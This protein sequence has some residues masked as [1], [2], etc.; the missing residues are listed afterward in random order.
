MSFSEGYLIDLHCD[1][2]DHNPLLDRNDQAFAA[3]KAEAWRIVKGDG[4]LVNRRTHTAACPHCAGHFP[5][6]PKD[7]HDH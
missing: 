3:S 5:T 6:A 7:T 1:R 4:W 2:P